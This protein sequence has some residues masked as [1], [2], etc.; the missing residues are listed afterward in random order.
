[1]LSS[2]Y[3]Q[4]EPRI[5]AYRC[6]DKFMLDAYNSGKDLYALMASGV[7][8]L[9][10]EQCLESYE[11]NGL[12]VGKERRGSMKSVLLGL[13]YGRQP[14][15]IGAQIGMNKREAEAFVAKFFKT[16][17]NIKKYIDDTIRDGTLL[18]YVT[19]ISGRRRR[20]PD[21]NSPLEFVRAE[22]QRQAVNA[23]IN[24][25]GRIL[26]SITQRCVA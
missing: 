22:A 6:N 24:M 16:Y 3:S 26:N 5:L 17:P 13:M 23:T 18:G 25:G 11:E 12:H 20:L 14:A 8:N 1:L 19:T 10:Y 7:Y 2:D 9:P 4:I 15:S 21:L